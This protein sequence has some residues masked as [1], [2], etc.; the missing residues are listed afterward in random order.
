MVTTFWRAELDARPS[1]VPPPFSG[2]QVVSVVLPRV[3][4]GLTDGERALI[5]GLERLLT[6]NAS[7]LHVELGAPFR[8]VQE[9]P[10]TGPRWLIGPRHCN[11]AVARLDLPPALAPLLHVDRRAQRLVSDSPDVSTS[12]E[13]LALL[14]RMHWDHAARLVNEDCATRE[15]AVLLVLREVGRTWPSFERTGIT[16]QEV[17]ARHVDHVMSADDPLPALERWLAE[18]GD[19]H[20]RVIASDARYPASFSARVVDGRLVLYEVPVG[21]RAWNAGAREGFT[22]CGID[23]TTRWDQV[24][25]SP[26]HKPFLVAHRLLSATAGEQRDFEAQSPEGA[27]VSWVEHFTA[28]PPVPL[29]SS[30]RLPSGAAYLRVRQWRPTTQVTQAID[31]AFDDART[32]PGLVVDLRG[33]GGGNLSMALDF[34]DRFVRERGL[35]GYRQFSDPWGELLPRAGIFAE[36]TSKDRRWP[37]PVR[38]LV[39]PLTYSASEDLLIGLSGLSHV[40]VLGVESGGGSGQ[41]R[42]VRLLPGCRLHVSSCLT[43][44]RA[45]RC[46]EGAGIRVDR[47]VPLAGAGASAWGVGLLAQA[48]RSW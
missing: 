10:G 30:S 26:H 42:A 24:G 7:A 17:C 22:L 18:L 44:D 3:V 11:P 2:E 5:Q 25:A 19:G 35:A 33:N 23:A 40:E 13:S 1:R 31:A 32:A 15:Q 45:G 46:I 16:W 20:T 43:F 38:F 36:P 39:D 27:R 21:S 9:D 8:C 4:D 14:R 12:S 34:R 48:D 29:V 6:S 28:E 41:A 47:R 37:K